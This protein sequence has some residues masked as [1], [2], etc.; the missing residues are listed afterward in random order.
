MER[1]PARGGGRWP[2]AVPVKDRALAPG[3]LKPRRASRASV[4]WRAPRVRD[5][6]GE[7]LDPYG[8]VWNMRSTVPVCRGLFLRWI[9]RRRRHGLQPRVAAKRLP[10][11]RMAPRRQPQRG[12]DRHVRGGAGGIG[13]NPVG[14]DARAPPRSQGRA[15]GPTLGWRPR[16]RW[17]LSE[18]RRKCHGPSTSR[19]QR[20]TGE[21]DG[22][23]SHGSA[24][25]SVEPA[26]SSQ[27]SSR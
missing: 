24:A 10:W 7:C 27:A 20:P 16:P 14:V 9:R 26:P 12:C 22:A 17:G 8:A 23:A 6:F 4:P 13:R 5:S 21:R 25:D 18:A 11:E 3:R 19:I 1:F 2:M 15:F